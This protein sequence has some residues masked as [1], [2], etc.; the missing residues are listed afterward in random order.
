VKPAISVMVALGT[1][2]PFTFISGNKLSGTLLSA[3]AAQVC[4]N[5]TLHAGEQIPANGPSPTRKGWSV[6]VCETSES[7]GGR[8]AFRFGLDEDSANDYREWDWYK[9]YPQCNDYF[10]SG[11]SSEKDFPGGLIGPEK[12]WIK[13]DNDPHKRDSEVCVLFG[14]KVKKDM[15]F[16]NDETH[17]VKNDESDGCHC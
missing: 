11:G 9:D 3:S 6:K 13:A 16:S 5:G 14:G 8:I 2:A 17:D 12:I 4:P 7:Q 10:V 15:T 1:I